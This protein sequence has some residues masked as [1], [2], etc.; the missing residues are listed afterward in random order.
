MLVRKHFQPLFVDSFFEGFVF[1][2]HDH[3]DDVVHRTSGGFHDSTDVFE[4][5]FA[6]AF[7]VRRGPSSLRLHSEYS[8]GHHERTYDA[9][10]WDW[11]FMTESRDFKAATSAHDKFTSLKECMV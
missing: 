1:S 7:N 2:P 4:H 9:S 8:A 10:H 3:F 11:V 5:Q 6:L